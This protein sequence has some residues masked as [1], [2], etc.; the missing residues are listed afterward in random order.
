MTRMTF[1]NSSCRRAIA[2]IAAVSTAVTVA[3]C[4]RGDSSDSDT[5]GEA[6]IGV[7]LITKDSTN[8]FFVAMQQGAKQAAA[9]NKV[10]AHHRLRQAGG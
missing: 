10:E 4:N 2:I 8:P 3:A 1:N 5:G 6:A 7:G 9:K